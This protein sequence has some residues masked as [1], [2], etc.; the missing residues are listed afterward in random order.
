MPWYDKEKSCWR[1]VV[2][3]KGRKGKRMM[4][5]FDTKHEAL[6]WERRLKGLVSDGVRPNMTVT[7]LAARFMLHMVKDRKAPRTQFDYESIL[8]LHIL[9]R[10]GEQSVC[11]LRHHDIENWYAAT[12][13][14]IRGRTGKPGISSTNKAATLLFGLLKYAV[15]LELLDKNP[16]E[17]V[18]RITWKPE[19][20]RCYDLAELHQLLGASKRPYRTMFAI[21]AMA[22]LMPSEWLALTWQDVDLQNAVLN[23]SHGMTKNRQGKYER[24]ATKTSYRVRKLPMPPALVAELRSHR[25]WCESERPDRCNPTDLLFTTLSGRP[26]SK[27][28]VRRDGWWP[29]VKTAGLPGAQMNS[30]R[31]SYQ[32][33]ISTAVPEAAFERLAGHARGSTVGRRFYVHQ[34]T[35][36]A[37]D[38][39]DA[40]FDDRCVNQRVNREDTQGT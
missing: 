10:F 13:A 15:T 21:G 33:I 3:P 1:G 24:G 16:V 32:T 6:E 28:N 22:G 5:R 2:R 4:K 11:E 19:E 39:V 12:L 40:A 35:L 31:H 9:P 38:L 36:G 37:R 20:K 34:T 27:D 18:D 8:D 7:E 17:G 14:D 26:M 30:L 29:A 23:V 25:Q